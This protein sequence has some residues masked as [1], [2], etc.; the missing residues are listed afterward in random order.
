MRQDD[1][2]IEGLVIGWRSTSAGWQ[3]EVIVVADD[4]TS[5]TLM[6]AADD[7]LP[8]RT[9]DDVSR[10]S[11]LLLQAAKDCESGRAPS[12]HE[13][14]TRRVYQSLAMVDEPAVNPTVPDPG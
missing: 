13:S 2:A 11:L 7:V 14:W 6:V 4:F 10:L 9:S 5:W 12:H 3:A 1:R 8:A